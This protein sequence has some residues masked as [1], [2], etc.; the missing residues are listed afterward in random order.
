M[1]ATHLGG[2][3]SAVVVVWCGVVWCGVWCG[4]C[5]MVVWSVVRKCTKR[6]RGVLCICWRLTGLR[7]RL[8]LSPHRRR[9]SQE[10]KGASRDRFYR[11]EAATPT[12][13][14]TN[15]DDFGTPAQD[16]PRKLWSCGWRGGVGAPLQD[17]EVVL[18]WIARR[19]DVRVLE[20]RWV[21]LGGW[22]G[23]VRAW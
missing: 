7:D 15:V 2:I 16:A 21:G 6:S 19:E 3:V 17:N 9:R 18:G 13:D 14:H 20:V 1:L 12:G 5:V 8:I 10:A 23:C 22:G 11:S 4:V